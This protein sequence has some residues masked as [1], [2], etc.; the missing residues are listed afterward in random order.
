[1]AVDAAGNVYVTGRSQAGGSGIDNFDYGTVKYDTA[2]NELWAARYNGPDGLG[3][4]VLGLALDPDGNVYV[5]GGSKGIGR[6]QR[7]RHR[8]IRR[9]PACSNGRALR[10]R[11]ARRPGQ[12]RSSSTATASSSPAISNTG[13][14]A[15]TR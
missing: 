3:D 14:R 1:M 8:Q 6:P 12:R 11:P 13:D 15:T 2:G 7:V 10:Q 9:R 5:T 4:E